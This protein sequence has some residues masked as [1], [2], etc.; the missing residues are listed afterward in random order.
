MFNTVIADCTRY[1]WI[2]MNG[3]WVKI[4]QLTFIEFS[5]EI[6][7]TDTNISCAFKN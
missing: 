1:H 6:L 7:I 2:C 3:I 5:V 4:I